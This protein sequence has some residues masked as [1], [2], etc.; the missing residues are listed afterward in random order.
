MKI[1]LKNRVYLCGL[2]LCLLGCASTP[3]G[4]VFLIPSD[5][6]P[7]GYT[8]KAEE[9]ALESAVMRIAVKPI[10]SD[11]L[12]GEPPII[13]ILAEKHYIILRLDIENRSETKLIFN[14]AYIS[15]MS[16]TNDYY[17]PLD[18]TDIYSIVN[19]DDEQTADVKGVMG[20]FYDL[21]LTLLPG[22]KA[23]KLLL[24][25]PL[26]PD[27]SSAELML[28][29]IYVGRKDLSIGVPLKREE[30]KKDKEKTET[31]KGA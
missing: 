16:D 13:A 6:G 25:P 9:W 1:F 8:L 10:R 28:R 4:P 19:A 20:R 17:K 22:K 18:Y 14:P 12:D 15:L 11:G 23:S 5:A 30:E 7:E 27:A 2:L 31:K 26:D 3:K 24:F 29:N 21:S